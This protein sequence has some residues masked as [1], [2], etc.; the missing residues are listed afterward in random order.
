MRNLVASLLVMGCLLLPVAARSEP[1]TADEARASADAAIELL[2]QVN[3]NIA[4]HYFH[5]GVW[6]KA[7]AAFDR[8]IA[9][10]PHV[11]DSY[12]NAAWLLW[13]A[14]KH[15]DAKRFYERLVTANPENPEA[16]FIVAT[17]YM[18]RKEPQLA[19]PWLQQAVEHGLDSPKRHLYGH[20]LEQ[21]GR[22][23]DAL[24]FWRRCLAEDPSDAVAQQ[25]IGKLTNPQP[26]PEKPATPPAPK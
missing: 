4:D 19:L 11:V 1:L 15:D 3:E 6:D 17:Y 13:S 16:Y 23:E 5:Q 21:V 7:V 25:Q 9:L 14:G 22:T 8:I 20:A 26:A 10:R 12:A 18:Y 2:V 24:A